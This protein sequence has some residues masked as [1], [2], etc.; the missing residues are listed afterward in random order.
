M[1]WYCLAFL[2]GAVL[3]WPAAGQNVVRSAGADRV[4]VTLYRDPG[5]PAEQ[6]IDLDWPEGF[7]LVTETRRITLPAGA[8]P[9]PPAE[10]AK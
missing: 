10:P 6:A 4:A 7:A 2:A 1:R 5:R 9:P 3:A 8:Q